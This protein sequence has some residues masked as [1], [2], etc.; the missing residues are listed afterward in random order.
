MPVN[1]GSYTSLACGEFERVAVRSSR[2]C[3]KPDGECPSISL[4]SRSHSAIPL[5]LNEIHAKV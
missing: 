1:I 4:G 5:F 3:G 2:V